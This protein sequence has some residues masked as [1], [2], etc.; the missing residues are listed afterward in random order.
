MS[1]WI[2]M[3]LDVLAS[4]PDEINAIENALKNPCAELIARRAHRSGMEPKD[5]AEDLK[6]IVTF[7]PI[8]NL[9]S[10]DPSVNKARR[11]ESAWKM[12]FWGLAISHLKFVSRDFP[13]AVFLAHYYDDQASFGGKIVIRAGEEIRCSHDG[14]HRAQAQE[15][16][17][18]NIF[19][20]YETEYDL[21]LEFGSLW[22]EWLEGMGKELAALT[23]HYGG[24]PGTETSNR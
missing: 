7:I 2:D 14:D 4:R 13:G 12:K 5:I 17:L 23:G 18:P 8:R 16:V 24:S 6:E 21:G 11:F 19:A 22:N 10:V 20:P 9:G 1:N 15:W 3:H